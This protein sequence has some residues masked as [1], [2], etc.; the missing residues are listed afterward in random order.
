[1]GKFLALLTI[2][3]LLALSCGEKAE[4]E[5][6]AEIKSAEEAP[7]AKKN[8]PASSQAIKTDY[9]YNPTVVIE[10]DFG[11]IEVEVF[12]DKSPEH[13]KNFMKLVNSGFYDGLIFHRVVPGFIIQGGDPYG[14]GT[15]GP[16][17]YLPA[18]KSDLHHQ[19]GSIAMAQSALGVSGSQFYICLAPQPHLDKQFNVFAKVTSGMEVVKKIASVPRDARDKPNGDVIMKKLY[20]RKPTA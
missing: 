8:E 13:S 7:V 9:D 14:T 6:V 3:S 1:M 15:G 18:E 17:Y 11:K 10:T 2:L 5:K 19:T 16:G 4:E 20:E 12:F